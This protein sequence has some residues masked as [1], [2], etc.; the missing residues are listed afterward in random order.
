MPPSRDSDRLRRVLVDELRRAGA[1]R[2]PATEDAFLAVPRELFVGAVLAERGLG[3]V[4]A[5]EALIT[6]RD[7]HGMPLS[8]SSQPTMM[9]TMLEQLEPRPGDRV[10]EVGAGT[11]YNAALLAHL[12][13][14]QGQ[15][16]TIDIDSDLARRARRALRA[17]GARARTV[18][19]DGR[20]GFP[21]RAPYDRMIVTACADAIPTAWLEQLADG[22]R[23]Q[24]PLRLDPDGAAIQLI[25]TFERHG[26]VLRSRT[27]TWGGFMPLHGG[28]GGWRPPPDTL[29]AARASAGQP[30]VLASLSGAGLRGIAQGR[31]RHVLAAVLA[32]PP[33]PVRQG[34]TDFAGGHPPL[35]LLFLLLRIAGRRRVSLSGSGRL[36]IGLVDQ[37]RRG[38]AVVSVRTPWRR[39]SAAPGRR[40]RW[41]LDGYGDPAAATELGA[42]LDEW[43]ALQK[44]GRT[45]LQ[46]TGRPRGDTVW[47]RFAWT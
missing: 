3:A 46:I 32:D 16:T 38:L 17:A 29:S 18:V 12:V 1:I 44:A 25:P 4:Y 35:L 43:Q 10:L 26:A 31:A 6:K 8:S 42:L 22:G 34:V 24:L 30:A 7:A 41:R 21:A 9:A 23:L 19:G 11:G 14:R 5:D 40:A 2:S 28:D 47:L 37:R 20:A 27:I 33:A 39:G 15:V 45:A 13:G 36:G